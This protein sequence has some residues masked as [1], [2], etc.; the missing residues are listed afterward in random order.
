MRPLILNYPDDPR[1][2]ENADAYLW[3]DDSGCS[4]HARRRAALAGLPSRGISYDFWTHERHEGPTS[5][6]IEAPLERLPLFVRRGLFCHSGPP[7][8][9]RAS[10]S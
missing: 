2:H 3:G 7:S 1:T 8:N 4:R 9:M 10:A 5:I 6:S